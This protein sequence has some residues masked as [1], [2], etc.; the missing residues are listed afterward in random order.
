MAVA[1]KKEPLG[2][3]LIDTSIAVSVINQEGIDLISNNTLKEQLIKPYHQ[4]D[5]EFV[6]YFEGHLDA[7]RGL[8]FFEEKGDDKKYLKFFPSE[9]MVEKNPLPLLIGGLKDTQTILLKL[10]SWF[11]KIA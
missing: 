7:P 2:Y 9:K 11:P 8:L 4:V 6:E 5:E 10:I 1:C 3:T